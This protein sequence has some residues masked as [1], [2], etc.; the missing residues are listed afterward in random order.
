MRICVAGIFFACM[1]AC[2]DY[3]YTPFETLKY[4]AED[5]H[6]SYVE[7]DAPKSGTVVVGVVGTVDTLNPLNFVGRADR[8]LSLSLGKLMSQSMDEPLSLYPQIAED[9][10]IKDNC[11]TF[12]IN[13][14]AHWEDGTP[15][16]AVDV[17]EAFVCW[18]REGTP[19]QKNIFTQ[20]QSVHITDAHRIAF[21]LKEGSTYKPQLIAFLAMMPVIKNID[22]DIRSCGP[23][24]L[25][26]Y[27]L[28]DYVKF[29]RVQDYWAKDLFVHKGRFNF[30]T[31]I[32]KYYK[33]ALALVEALRK[34]IVDVC[35]DLSPESIR[36]LDR[37]SSQTHLLMQDQTRPVG[38][39][40]L[41][42]NTRHTFFHDVKV[43][44]ALY[45]IFDFHWFNQISFSGRAVQ[46]KSFFENTSYASSE[47]L[48]WEESDQLWNTRLKSARRLLR[49]AGWKMRDGVLY[50]QRF[51]AN[52]TF[53]IMMP[54]KTY[55]KV[56]QEFVRRLRAVGITSSIHVLPEVEF[57][58][59]KNDF[60]FDMAFHQWPG[61]RFPNY[62]LQS[63]FLSKFAHKQ[64]S[65]NYTGVVNDQVDKLIEV[66]S[67]TYNLEKLKHSGQALD[68]MLRKEILVIPFYYAKQH[69]I[70]SSKK[71]GYPKGGTVG[72]FISSWWADDDEREAHH[73][74][75]SPTS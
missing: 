40:G 53:R 75:K 5:T 23:Y 1:T 18:G 27:K 55:T 11:V 32:V 41:I 19:L 31:V 9:L 21:Q 25:D 7:P 69:I 12:S 34:G 48:P 65:K 64:G 33:N 70:A 42:F 67:R 2:S 61:H 73:V 50:N 8:Y 24:K 54:N 68:H 38:M 51:N 20:I 62:S 6:F 45:L 3:G 35:F 30:D 28:G 15:V 63:H 46:I 74:T 57:A 71:F 52:F 72:A 13:P 10:S 66:I 39:K 14:K 36:Y 60:N 49:E 59:K 44:E 37:L 4:S 56:V 47:V 58:Q 22:G 26:E 16:T 29:S 43:R 17:K